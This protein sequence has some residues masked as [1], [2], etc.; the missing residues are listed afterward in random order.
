MKAVR[1]VSANADAA[2]NLLVS[3]QIAKSLTDTDYC[4]SVGKCSP[5]CLG[6][7]VR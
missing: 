1:L 7:I 3:R 4:A 2:L 5:I 6:L